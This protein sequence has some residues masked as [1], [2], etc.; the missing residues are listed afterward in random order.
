MVY[1]RV[2]GLLGEILYRPSLC[3]SL[4]L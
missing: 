3:C 1:A 4:W 2:M